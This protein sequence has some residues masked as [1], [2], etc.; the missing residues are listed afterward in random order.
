MGV[1]N[2]IGSYTFARKRQIFL[3][4]GD[5]NCTLLTM[6]RGELIS[7]LRYTR[8]SN[9][10]LDKLSA[11]AVR[12]NQHLVD[13]A[14]LSALH[15]CTHVLLGMQLAPHAQLITVR[16]QRCCLTNNNIFT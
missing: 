2:D 9:T 13:N 6:S 10:H 5:T 7:H 15:W 4:V 12:R 14:A 11:F 16:R 8:R 1:D 3:T